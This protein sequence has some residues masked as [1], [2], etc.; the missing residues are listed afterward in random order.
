MVTSCVLQVFAFCAGLWEFYSWN[1]TPWLPPVAHIL[2][3]HILSC[4]GVAEWDQ[5]DLRATQGTQGQHHQ[6]TVE[7]SCISSCESGA[8]SLSMYYKLVKYINGANKWKRRNKK[9]TL[10]GKP[11]Q[12]C[13]PQGQRTEGSC[14]EGG[15]W[16]E[17]AEYCV[18][19]WFKEQ[20]SERPID[21][22]VTF[23]RFGGVH[24]EYWLATW[25]PEI[26]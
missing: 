11:L 20:V 5:D 18:L 19:S 21:I 1:N 17:L 22:L 8:L 7:F 4:S 12:K 3:G 13:L 24:F 2:P 26:F 14:C 10:V 16:L 6:V 9:E 25:F 23:N 15:R